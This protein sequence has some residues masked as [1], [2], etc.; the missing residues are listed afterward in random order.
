MYVSGWDNLM[1]ITPTGRLPV[2]KSPFGKNFEAMPVFSPMGGQG[3][4]ITE[5]ALMEQK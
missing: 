4:I 5:Q 3:Q 2:R 1:K